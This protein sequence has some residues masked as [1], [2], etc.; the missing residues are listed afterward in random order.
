MLR[1]RGGRAGDESAARSALVVCAFLRRG[2][3]RR[4]TRRC[5]PSPAPAANAG[6]RAG[7]TTARAARAWGAAL[8][9]DRRPRWR[10]GVAHATRPALNRDD[11][12]LDELLEAV[13][14]GRAPG[15]GQPLPDDDAPPQPR[16]GGGGGL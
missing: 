2:A 9:R 16:D 3:S 1:R 14:R 15:P 11:L 12:S 7:R 10:A 4:T 5:P 8:A 13:V 6:T